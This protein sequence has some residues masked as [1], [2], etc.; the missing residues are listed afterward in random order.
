MERQ[1]SPYVCHVFI[2]TN[3]R[4]GAR[5][6]CADGEAVALR[7]D[8]KK[9][10]EQRGWKPRVRVSQS[11]CLGLCEKGPNVMIYPQGIW[12]GGATRAD[13]GRILETIGSL[14]TPS[15]EG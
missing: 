9:Q 8:L 6:S 10:V 1:S 3:D 2:C 13:A 5:K 15:A 4:H 12:F 7:D 14:L 11:G